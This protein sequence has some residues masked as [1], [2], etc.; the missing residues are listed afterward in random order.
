MLSL[1]E[2]NKRCLNEIPS[3]IDYNS[4]LYLTQDSK[5]IEINPK[6]IILTTIEN[7]EKLNIPY[8]ILKKYP[9]WFLI[10]NKY[11]YLKVRSRMFNIINELLGAELSLYMNLPTINP[12]LAT[13][14]DVIIG[15]IAQNFRE[16]Q[17][18]Y[19]YAKDLKTVEQ[20]KI[21][22]ILKKIIL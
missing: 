10:E 20:Y 5:L 12:Q 22:R 9:D 2:L 15:T 13:N 18:K 14:N 21:N 3:H 8:P 17:K 1:K 16:P 7:A 11:Y 19:V 6:N 4:N